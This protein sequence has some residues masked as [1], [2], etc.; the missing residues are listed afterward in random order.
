MKITNEGKELIK[1][2]EGLALKAY[3]DVTGYAIGYGQHTY[4]DGKTVQA[5]H[6]ITKDFANAEFD[7]YIAKW[8]KDVAKYITS[9]LS[10][11]QFSAVVSY[12]YNRGLGA[13]SK[14][15]LLKMINQNPN[16]SR[17]KDQFVIE[18]GTSTKYKTTLIKRRKAE[19]EFYSKGT[20]TNPETTKNY[21]L[22]GA[23][24]VVFATFLSNPSYWISQTK[25]IFNTIFRKLKLSF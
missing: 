19:A 2:Y 11:N 20:F 24:F 14:S 18:W 25:F 4:S 10:D 9:N 12:A 8:E 13:F 15:T 5:S 23:L 22:Y 1:Y 3:F 21:I 7:K 17:I 16:D 6:K